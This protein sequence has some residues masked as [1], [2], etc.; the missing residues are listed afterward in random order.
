ATAADTLLRAAADL[1]PGRP[2]VRKIEGISSDSAGLTG[3]RVVVADSSGVVLLDYT[4]PDENPGRKEYTIFTRG[5]ER[6]AKTP[7]EMKVEELVLDGE[8]KIKE[9]HDEVGA[10]LLYR[11]LERDLGNSKA[12]LVLGVLDYS[13]GRPDSAVVHLEKTLERDPYSGEACYYLA[14]ARLEQGDTAWAERSL[15]Y[16]ARTDAY[17]SQRE[18]L[19]GR[20]GWGCGKLDEA[21]GHL[22]EAALAGG[23][24]LS[25]RNLLALVYRRQGRAPEALAEIERTLAIDP[26]DR[27]SLAEKAW[28]TGSREDLAELARLLGGQSQEAVELAAVYRRLG[29]WE[30]AL[31]VLKLVEQDNRDVYGTPA[32]FYYTIGSTLQALDRYEEAGSYF[33]KGRQAGA[34]LDRFPF[35]AESVQPLAQAVVHNPRDATARYLLGCLL[36]YRGRHAEAIFQW[37]RGV[38]ADS[39][40]FSLQR[41]L[42]LA[43]YENGYEI[44][45]A[46]EHLERV[47]AINPDHVR[48]FT[49]LSY[50]YSREGY[51][52]RQ[53]TLLERALVRSPNDDNIIE[54]LISVKLASGSLAAAD[55]LISSHQFGQR[56]RDYRL[57]DKYRWLHYGLA[58]R[59]FRQ[60]RLDLASDHLNKALFPP[61]TLGADDFQFQ[62]APRLH[63]YLGLVLEKAG[64]SKQAREEFE[65][66]AT[67]W[68]TLSSDRDSY[69]SENLYMALS[70]QKLGQPDPAA[71]LIDSM[72]HFARGQLEDRYREHRG[73]AYY[74]LGLAE[75]YAGNSSEA[76]RL[77]GESSRI[78]P[79]LLGPRFELRGDVPDPLS[80]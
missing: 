9:M 5:L 61:G 35:R 62:S 75:K 19:L 33:D 70:L 20:I 3:M 42:G 31:R 45:R 77:L 28:I 56:H 29:C 6:P 24:N 37:E 52:D 25:A 2:L 78:E 76:E 65:K 12:H 30:E 58:S 15:H 26:T 60:G 39:G 18:Y 54:G 49:D 32:I 36:Y 79:D 66:S 22:A 51:F 59:A 72:T 69:N 34:N 21:A 46:A 80:R 55:S 38:E 63:Y 74:L 41:S 43:Y 64:K 71:R 73:E 53:A 48:T 7:E 16:I 11:A 47:I 17:Y 68:Q 23:Y 67:G 4:R 1:A 44:A 57:R 27:W 14:L 50:I 10:G 40:H 13:R 8:T